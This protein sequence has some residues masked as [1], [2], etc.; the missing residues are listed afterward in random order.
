MLEAHIVDNK[1]QLFD[2]LMANLATTFG[3][4][5]NTQPVDWTSYMV[6]GK[7]KWICQ[8]GDKSATGNTPLDA[9]MELML[10]S[11]A[12]KSQVM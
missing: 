4:V 5:R 3:W 8:V 11:F 6:A 2:H 7:I 12:G 1:K 9:A 10:A